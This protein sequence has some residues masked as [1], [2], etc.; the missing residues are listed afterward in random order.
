MRQKVNMEMFECYRATTNIR[1]TN[2]IAWKHSRWRKKNRRLMKQSSSLV[3]HHHGEG[4]YGS[5]VQAAQLISFSCVCRVLFLRSAEQFWP[6][7]FILIISWHFF[8]YLMK[9]TSKA[10]GRLCL[11]NDDYISVFPLGSVMWWRMSTE[12]QREASVVKLQECCR[13]GLLLWWSACGSWPIAGA[14]PG[15]EPSTISNIMRPRLRFNCWKQTPASSSWSSWSRSWME[16]YW[17]I[18][19]EWSSR[20]R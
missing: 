20:F 16:P 3:N 7:P 18:I 15:V 6:T 14:L 13:A 2:D 11:P 1:S 10:R 9:Q 19:L 12:P 17:T 8:Y 4:S 5:Y